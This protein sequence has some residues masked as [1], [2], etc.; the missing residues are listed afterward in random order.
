M[1]SDRI[2]RNIERLLDEADTAFAARDWLRVRDCAQDVLSLD[3]K[4]SEARSFLEAAERSLSRRASP[5]PEGEGGEGSPEHQHQPEQ[6]LGGAGESPALPAAAVPPLVPSS[7]ASGR[8]AVKRFL[9]EGGKKKVYLAHDTLLDRDVAFALIKTEGL[10]DI[11]RDRITREAQAMGRLGTHPHI[12][13]VFDLGTEHPLPLGEGGGEGTPY[14]VTELMG[15]GDVEELIKKAPEHRPPLERTLEVGIE[16]CRGLEFAHSHGIV[17]R[18]L[19]PGNVWLTK[20]T[21]NWQ[22]ATGA[23]TAAGSPLPAAA[24]VAKLGD[25]GLAVALDRSRLTQAGMMVGTVS[26]MPPEQALGGEV[27]PRSDLYSLGAML[28]EMVTGRP[29]FV[30]DESVA[31][32]TQHLNTAP[33]SPTW[34]NPETPP[35]LE[36]LIMRLLEKDPAKRPAGAGGVRQALEHIARRDL[37]PRPPSLRGKGEDDGSPPRIAE[38]LGERSDNPMYR[39]T[40]VGREAELHQLQAAFDAATSGQGS[41]AMVVGEPGIGKTSLCKQLA[42]YAT[43]RSGKMLVGHCYEEGSLSLPY[44]PF[45]EAMRSYVLTREPEGLKQD[46][47]S[48]AGD[49]ARIVSEV[50]DRIPELAP[51]GSSWGSPSP[52]RKGLLKV[53]APAPSPRPFRT[54]RAGVRETPGHQQALE[55]HQTGDPEEE[56]YRLYQAVTGFLRNAAAVR[57]LVIV[58][59][60]L[61]DADRGTLDLLLH[62][63]RNLAGSRLL[64]VG[65]YR[66]IEVDRSHPLSAT[67]AELRRTSGFRRVLLRGLTADEVQRM[68]SGLSGQDVRWELAE[69]VHRQTEGNPLFVQEVLRYLV[70]E[71]LI[72][73]EG[74]HWRASGDTPLA[75]SIPEGLR[76]VIGKRLSRLSPDCNRLLAIAAV[77]GRDFRLDTLQAV[78]GVAE[79]S[80]L[81]ALE[82]ATR[83]AVLSEQARVGGVEYRFAHAFFRQTLYEELSVPRRLRMHQE[84]AR[85]LERQYGNRLEEHAAE[86][87][88]HF[89]Q[90]TDADD[91]RKAIFYAER[92]AQRA[93][94]VYAYGEAARHLE[95]ALDVQEVLDPDDKVKRCDLLLALGGALMPAGEPARVFETVAAQALGLAEALED[96]DRASR[97]CQMAIEALRRYGNAAMGGT[98]VHRQWAE[99]ADRYAAPG[100]IDRV[101]ADLA[102]GNVREGDGR[103]AEILALRERALTLAR[104]LNDPRT[105]RGAAIS[106]VTSTWHLPVRQVNLEHILQVTNELSRY[107][108]DGV[109]ASGVG[110]ALH[111][112]GYVWLNAGDRTRAEDAWHEL[113]DLAERTKDT[114]LL[115]LSL[116]NKIDE[117]MLDGQLEAADAGATRVV[118]R[119]DDLGAPVAG[120]FFAAVRGWRHLLYLDRANAALPEL[121]Q[122][123]A[124]EAE[125]GRVAWNEQARTALVL[126]YLGRRDEARATMH[127][128][129]I[130][131]K[132]ASEEHVMV[133]QAGVNLLETAVLLKDREAA[134]LLAS[135][136]R[137]VAELAYGGLAQ[138]CVARHLGAA[139]A[140]LGER[141]EA[142]TSY[143]Q[144]LEVCEK[145]RFRPEIALTHFGIAELL[146]DDGDRAEALGHLDFAIA[147]FRE[148]K[149][150]PS[151][152]RA[153][154]HKEVL[155][156]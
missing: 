41:L 106:T 137:P 15:G 116:A 113:A 12:V 48:G 33:V 60:D 26:Y 122:R 136:L 93:L 145:I 50:R 154:R 45:V 70:E 81:A 80:L 79:E 139:A 2:Q 94:A 114:Q 47:G 3:P 34:H 53:T 153:L 110:A 54:E 38:G 42:T 51:G 20:A 21:G 111:F 147:E 67:L 132:V 133:I 90:S 134:G 105:F 142:L 76:D 72:T 148:M 14:I 125:R 52:L 9:G 5:L 49:I 118:S 120:R 124:I 43:I 25:F 152:E 39:R 82:E 92:A 117:A 8:Y 17:H 151:L 108:R 89:A 144:A 149:M 23:G 99:G 4:Q 77:I 127:R 73:R 96:S 58:L 130:D 115:L 129:L 13:S 11:G 7:F 31:I 57:P 24:P 126:T 22:P 102:L 141:E 123:A 128:L 1:T 135:R 119:G 44:L 86:L 83:A 66:D 37:T 101:L 103:L 100:T 65:T 85:V 146:L 138:T 143:E 18:D 74:G 87:A 78:A 29:P 91:L 30:G 56:R 61:H 68:L 32:I 97:T 16:V 150:Q 69:A 19:K 55:P 140:L 36:A 95:Q 10:D 63:S 156:A 62:L 35:A 28:Y 84:V 27:T 121:G 131:L 155:K 98:A 107:S 104:Q 6:P 40:F 64:L 59:E 75:V 71:G 109:P 88:E 46:L 112:S